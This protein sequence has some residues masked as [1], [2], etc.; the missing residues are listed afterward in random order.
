MNGWMR[1]LI[2]ERR[3]KKKGVGR[4]K[5]SRLFIPTDQ[6]EG[7]FDS[8]VKVEKTKGTHNIGC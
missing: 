2:A 1:G 5:V 8:L 4:G 6:P 7:I 3:E